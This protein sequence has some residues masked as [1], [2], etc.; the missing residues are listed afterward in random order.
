VPEYAIHFDQPWLRASVVMTT[1]SQMASQD[2]SVNSLKAEIA[3][4][5]FL[6][7]IVSSNNI[8]NIDA[9][10]FEIRSRKLDIVK[11]RNR[12][13][14]LV[15]TYRD[16]SAGI[17]ST[18]HDQGSYP[19]VPYLPYEMLSYIFEKAPIRPDG[20]TRF[21]TSVS[22]VS[23]SWRETA[24]QTPYLW[25]GIYLPVWATGDG[26][27]RSLKI[28]V[29]R[30]QL[31]PLDITVSL[32]DSIDVE[33]VS[34]ILHM[35][36]P[37]VSRWRTFTYE[38]VSAD[39]VFDV[40]KPLANLSAPLLESLDLTVTSLEDVDNDPLDLFGGG[41]LMLSRVHMGGVNLA[42]FLPPLSSVTYLRLEEAS[43]QIT[44]RRFLDL[45]RSS[46]VLVSLHLDG[47]IV[48]ETHLYQ[49]TLQEQKVEI[50]SLRYFSFTAVA[51]LKYYPES[52]LNTIRCPNLELLTISAHSWWGG[53]GMR[54]GDI[55]FAQPLSLAS[56]TMLH[57][58]ELPGINCA[59]FV[60]YFDVIEL[61]ALDTISLID[62]TSLMALLRILLPSEGRADNVICW[63]LLRII[64]LS[65]LGVD[66]FNGLGEIISYRQACDKPI[67]IVEIDPR[68]LD[69]F[70]AEVEDM[71]QHLVVRQG[72]QV[73]YHEPLTNFPFLLPQ[74]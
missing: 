34:G 16:K 26:Y 65:H 71:K 61:L 60:E 36:I 56:Y 73:H 11:L 59:E 22:Q 30:S 8:G 69:S 55:S 27:Q 57:T 72:A 54:L 25:S 1:T 66:E 4:L 24:K 13:R 37:E 23:H 44:G 70:P 39:D 38:G 18:I 6:L 28:F 74:P 10:T 50:P 5:E 7:E 32:R 19:S 12:L 2:D 35:I 45:L 43:G 47:A 53:V 15:S 40:I 46:P 68:S 3:N 29:Q 20:R 67:E 52:L 51:S 42:S 64:K 17:H 9:V 62:C 58:I 41:A 31:H 63:P 14:W 48:D 49:L 33:D 21:A